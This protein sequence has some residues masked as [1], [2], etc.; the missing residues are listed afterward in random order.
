M[1]PHFTQKLDEFSRCKLPDSLK[2]NICK[3]IYSYCF[4]YGVSVNLDV[5]HIS[6]MSD[7]MKSIF[8]KLLKHAYAIDSRTE[9]LILDLIKLIA[10]VCEDDGFGSNPGNISSG[11]HTN[12]HRDDEEFH[13]SGSCR[14]QNLGNK[15]V[16]PFL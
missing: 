10:N 15:G 7:A 3:L 2:E 4:N 8:C 13:T 14:N 1:D 11:Q 9:K 6:S 5:N 16:A 12:I